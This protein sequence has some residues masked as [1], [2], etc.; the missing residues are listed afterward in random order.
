[1]RK[2]DVAYIISALG[3]IL[4]LALILRA[5]TSLPFPAPST[6][7]PGPT[8][9]GGYN[10]GTGPAIFDAFRSFRAAN[11]Y[12]AD[13][14]VFATVGAHIAEKGPRWSASNNP[15]V[16]TQAV[17]T[18]AAGGA[19]VQHVVDC[20]IWSAFAT[21]AP[22][23]S[24]VQVVVVDGSTNIIVVG[25]AVPASTGLLLG[26]QGLCGLNLVGTANTS[27]SVAFGAAVT[28][29]SESVTITGYNIN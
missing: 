12:P 24:G 10:G 11:A 1:M 21:T 29:L 20:I 22:S 7:I 28:N 16:G 14:T 8:L 27:M 15:T 4:V 25:L 19:G 26:P 17:A 13:G 9:I 3:L 2:R 5:Q 18:I 23:L 6:A